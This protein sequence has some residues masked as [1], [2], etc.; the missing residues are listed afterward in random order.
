ME[1]KGIKDLVTSR[2]MTIFVLC[3]QKDHLSTVIAILGIW[4]CTPFGAGLRLDAIMKRQLT[5]NIMALKE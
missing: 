1:G 4:D 3:V 2:P 5:I